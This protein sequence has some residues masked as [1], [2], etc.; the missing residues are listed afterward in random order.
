M[1]FILVISTFFL[2]I[3]ADYFI[4][5]T[6]AEKRARRMV[7]G[8]GPAGTVPAMEPVIEYPENFQYDRSHTW[9][10][11][12]PSTVTVG[13][14]D[15]TQRFT[16]PIDRIECAKPGEYVEKGQPIWTL[17]FGSRTITQKAPISGRISQIHEEVLRDP[18]IVNQDPYSTG[19]ILK[20]QPKSVGEEAGSLMDHGQFQEWNHLLKDKLLQEMHPTMGVVYGDRGELVNGAAKEIKT[21][22]WSQV[23]DF[24]FNTK[25]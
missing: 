6:L 13:L 17:Y 22:R 5:R 7:E 25:G 19:W 15:F 12:E 24:L 3:L 4:V 2:A 18:S 9:A 16:G 20:I 1:V 21:E 8:L 11:L 10:M 14:D 23:I